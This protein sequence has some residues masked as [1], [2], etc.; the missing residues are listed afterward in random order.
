MCSFFTVNLVMQFPLSKRLL[1]WGK[2]Y[3]KLIARELP[4]IQ[5]DD[6]IIMLSILFS[7]KDKITQ[8][9]LAELLSVDK[10]RISI[11]VFSLVERGYVYIERNQA[12]RREHHV[13]LTAEGT[14]LIP[15]IQKAIDKVNQQIIKNLDEHSLL[16][17]YHVL[18]QMEDNLSASPFPINPHLN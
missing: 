8:K 5:S 3:N 13:S 1:H 14:A 10:S 6:D 17:F 2:L 15:A 16:S 7:N 12:D 11:M 9:E 4:E 18:A